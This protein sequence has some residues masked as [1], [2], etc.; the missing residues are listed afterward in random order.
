MLHLF[1]EHQYNAKP[2]KINIEVNSSEN[3]KS[4]FLNSSIEDLPTDAFGSQ[5]QIYLATNLSPRQRKVGAWCLLSNSSAIWLPNTW[6]VAFH[7][8]LLPPLAMISIF[9]V[10]ICCRADCW[11]VESGFPLWCRGSLRVHSFSVGKVISTAD[12]YI[13][14]QKIL[15]KMNVSLIRIFG[16]VIWMGRWFRHFLYVII[17]DVNI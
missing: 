3:E 5:Q 15:E 8:V 1:Q 17:W 11:H 2:S 10:A 7:G 12:G 16:F 14:W 6:G 9:P 4:I 13:C